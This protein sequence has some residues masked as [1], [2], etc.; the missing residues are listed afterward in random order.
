MKLTNLTRLMAT[1]AFGLI[2]LLGTSVIADA[3]TYRDYRRQ[4]RRIDRQERRAE[5]E[6]RQAIRAQQR[7]QR[8]QYRVYNNGRYYTT[9][10]RGVQILRDAVN[11]GYQ[12][13]FYAG[14]QARRT[15]RY[16]QRGEPPA[17]VRHER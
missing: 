10:N 1:G 2:A 9:D 11:R 5:R 15:G 13:G 7:L 14:E 8:M 4:E 16:G 17:A 3:Q 6:R 12:Q